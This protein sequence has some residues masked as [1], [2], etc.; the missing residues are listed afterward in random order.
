MSV[1]RIRIH[2]EGELVLLPEELPGLGNPGEAGVAQAA[3]DVLGHTGF[4]VE[5]AEITDVDHWKG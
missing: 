2:V 3:Q 4:S 1:R 5:S